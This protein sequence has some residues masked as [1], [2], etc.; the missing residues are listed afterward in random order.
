ML[1]NLGADLKITPDDSDSGIA[2]VEHTLAPHSLGAPLHRHSREDEISYVLDGEMSVQQGEEVSTVGAGEFVVKRRDVWHTFWNSGSEP[3]RFLEI[4]A[5]GD[6][7]GYF[8]EMA[9]VWEGGM[10]DEETMRQIGEIGEKYGNESKPE[11]IPEL[12][13]RH[14]L[15]L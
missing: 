9:E 12:C 11:S 10:P 8:E 4:I 13:Q 6:F 15:T 3:V 14:G 2:V 7:A 5:P 1:G